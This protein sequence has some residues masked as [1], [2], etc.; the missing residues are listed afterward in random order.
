MRDGF[1]RDK[2]F[3]A[4]F[5]LTF[6]ISELVVKLLE[7]WNKSTEQKEST[8]DLLN[9]DFPGISIKE[10]SG[11]P[12]NLTYKYK[13]EFDEPNDLDRNIDDLDPKDLEFDEQGWDQLDD[14]NEQGK[15]NQETGGSN[16]RMNFLKSMQ[17][18]GQN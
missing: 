2:Y 11:N 15:G 16:S 4:N 17:G 13:Y 6:K 18:K 8:V 5:R 9:L 14:D 7:S 3:H 12:A 1:Q 10:K